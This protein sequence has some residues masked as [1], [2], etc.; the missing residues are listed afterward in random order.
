MNT[1]A[2][3]VPAA[4]DTRFQEANAFALYQI[5]YAVRPA[6]E[7]ERAPAS[8]HRDLEAL[9]AQAVP[10]RYTEYSVPVWSAT[11]GGLVVELSTARVRLDSN[12]LVRTS[13]DAQRG[14]VRI[15]AAR[16]MLSPG[17]FLV[18]GS[19]PL[20]PE[21]QVLRVYLHVELRFCPA[22][23]TP[24]EQRGVPATLLRGQESER[25]GATP[26]GG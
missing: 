21:A 23:S 13:D 3:S 14:H 1:L 11:E 17:F 5:V 16:P 19:R 24:E 22:P 8:Q 26:G 6:S 9:L 15:S 10:H 18:D 25:S 4:D 12:R 20:P 2:R 7:T